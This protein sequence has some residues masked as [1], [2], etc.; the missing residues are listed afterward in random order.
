MAPPTP[1]KP[2]NLTKTVSMADIKRSS[3]GKQDMKS[4]GHFQDTIT[5]ERSNGEI[6]F[7]KIEELSSELDLDQNLLETPKRKPKRKRMETPTNTKH[8]LTLSKYSHDDLC[9]LFTQETN[10]R[11]VL[12]EFK[13][14]KRK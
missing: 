3:D 8:C 11:T 5:K 1:I 13:Y 6:I 2:P 12:G 7:E 10:R 4:F 9:D 14:D